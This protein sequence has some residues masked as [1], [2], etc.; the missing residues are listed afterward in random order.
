MNS[1][2]V[3][4]DYGNISADYLHRD[5]EDFKRIHDLDLQHEILDALNNEVEQNDGNYTVTLAIGDLVAKYTKEAESDLFNLYNVKLEQ[6]FNAALLI[7]T[8]YNADNPD[9]TFNW[10]DTHS[11]DDISA[12][13]GPT[14]RTYEWQLVADCYTN[15][16]AIVNRIGAVNSSF[17][18]KLT[19][20][21]LNDSSRGL[22]IVAHLDSTK[23]LNSAV[24]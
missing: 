21:Q 1:T 2:K 4:I 23:F 5:A 12:Y 14:Y 3:T 8:Q 10:G 19:I 17:I 22:E 16:H 13:N 6:L 24:E 20:A 11:L 7:E 9:N 18:H 15:G